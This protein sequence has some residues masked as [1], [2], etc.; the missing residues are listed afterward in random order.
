MATAWYNVRRRAGRIGACASAARFADA[1]QRREG[2]AR[3]WR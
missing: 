3:F 1:S 2:R